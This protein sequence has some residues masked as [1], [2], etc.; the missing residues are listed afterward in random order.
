[1]RRGML[2]QC[3]NG[4]TKGRNKHRV[5]QFLVDCGRCMFL[6]SIKADFRIG[7]DNRSEIAPLCAL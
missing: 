3:T 5:D 7:M 4:T 6:F 2:S 1:M